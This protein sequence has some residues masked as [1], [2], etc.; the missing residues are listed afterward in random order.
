MI[1][2]LDVTVL[3][4]SKEGKSISN[5]EIC[6]N[7]LNYFYVYS[8][9]ENAISSRNDLNPKNGT[10]PIKLLGHR[11]SGS[12]DMKL[13]NLDLFLLQQFISWGGPG[14]YFF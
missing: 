9:A 1:P 11:S 7:S 14:M 5:N 12:T 2:Y 10:F 3:H 8:S 13:T 6:N 4:L